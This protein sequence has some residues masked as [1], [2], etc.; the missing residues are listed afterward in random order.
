MKL[1]VYFLSLSIL[2]FSACEEVPPAIDFTNDSSSKLKGKV[3]SPV[4]VAQHK[5]VLIEDITGV[6]CINCPD[7]AQKARDII[8]QKTEDSVVVVAQYPI[9]I[10]SNFTFPWP[11]VP[12]LA[13][14]ISKQIVE[15]LGIPQGLPSGF[16]DRKIYNGIS[17]NY[18]Y[19]LWIN[20]VNQQLR[21]KTP[22]NIS[23]SK[24]LTNRKLSVDMKLQYNAD[25][26]GD[27]AHK[28][29]IYLMEDSIVSTQY[30][31]SGPSNTKYVHNHA[32]RYAFGL[33]MGNSLAGPN[34][35]GMTYIKTY[36]YEV[37][38]EYN[39]AHC[40]LVCLV[41]DAVTEEVINVREIDL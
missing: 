8:A 26:S 40:H 29:A 6:R 32:L 7:A 41:M 21:K 19:P 5:A 25:A 2:L 37:P 23:L 31:H 1:S 22:V 27:N 10:L 11:G 16:I 18:D 36:D 12:K 28:Y 38:A 30:D 17:R 33:P 15:T 34:T 13:N 9:D 20:Y 14:D 24:T 39:L 35:A 4:P 3:E